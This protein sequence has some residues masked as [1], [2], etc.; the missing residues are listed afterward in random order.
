MDPL[1]R[2]VSEITTSRNSTNLQ[3]RPAGPPD[4]THRKKGGHHKL[5]PLHGVDVPVVRKGYRE[6]RQ[7]PLPLILKLQLYLEFWALEESNVC[8]V[9]GRGGLSAA[10]G[11]RPMEGAHGRLEDTASWWWRFR[12]ERRHFPNPQEESK[13]HVGQSDVSRC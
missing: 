9:G 7:G 4:S 8:R 1:L 2:T 10:G 12:R 11:D 13:Q 3:Q 5:R 6:V